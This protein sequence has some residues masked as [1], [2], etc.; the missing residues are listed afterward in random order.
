M[1]EATETEVASYL[2][3]SLPKLPHVPLSRHSTA[4]LLKTEETARKL[5]LDLAGLTRRL[6][7]LEAGLRAR[8]K[9]IEKQQRLVEAARGEAAEA[10]ARRVQV[11]G[12]GREGGR[13]MSG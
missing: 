1:R 6:H 11:G 7:Q 8:D 2:P 9:E 5:D 3:S 4:D 10:D 12:G 13:R